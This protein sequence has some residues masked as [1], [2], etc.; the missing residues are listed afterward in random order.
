MKAKFFSLPP[1]LREILDD[2]FKK[3]LFLALFCLGL[4]LAVGQPSEDQA[5]APVTPVVHFFFHPAC[6][7]CQ[8]QKKFNQ[9]LQVKYPEV[10]LLAHDISNQENAAL[11]AKL[12][13]QAGGDS[14]RLS[15]P[16]TFAGPYVISG[17]QSA[18][19]TGLKIEQALQAYL[20]ND[21]SLA[22][23]TDLSWRER[24]TKG[25]LELPLV[26]EIRLADYPL[27]ALAV[28][29][30]LVDG[31]NPCAMWVL[32]Y[33]ISVIITIQDRRKIWF[34]VGSFVGAS[35]VLYFLFMSAWL[36][37]FLYI[38]YLRFLTLAVGLFAMGAGV[39]SLREFIIS[40]GRLTC[41]V[42]D[43]HYK[44]QTM[45]RIE[46]IVHAPL[47]LL[48]VVSV[49]LL[50]FMVN[51]IEFVCSAALPAIFTHTL[52]LRQL[53][54][55]EYYGYILIY[56][57]FFMLDDLVI[58]S[59]AALAMDT[60]IGQRYAKHCKIMGGLLLLGLGLIMTFWPEMLR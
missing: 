19:T 14:S 48:S 3:Y 23:G 34:L 7:F 32:V 41:K 56:D 52:S 55:V 5:S 44:K 53:P 36:N 13:E 21:P 9:Y 17:F 25:R 1:W 54:A 50:A 49:I 6:Q 57:F 29:I 42:G 8:E 28:L 40:K 10:Q 35:G 46:R 16:M 2:P 43:A 38:G 31:F 11:Q 4:L 37:I 30:G 27:L 18:A 24:E 33:L 60:A 58:F 47:N 22:G 26:G 20:R 39:L 45:G 15:V 51:S 59:L 12:I